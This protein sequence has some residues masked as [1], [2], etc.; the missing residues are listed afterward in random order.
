[1]SVANLWKIQS[2]AYYMCIL[3]AKRLPCL[4]KTATNPGA[5]FT[6]NSRVLFDGNKR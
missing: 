4:G 3:S 2:R 1:M 5:M 6:G